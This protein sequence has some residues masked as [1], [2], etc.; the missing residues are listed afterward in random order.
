[1]KFVV[2][3]IVRIRLWILMRDFD[4]RIVL[5]TGSEEEEVEGEEEREIGGE[6][7]W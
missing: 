4:L 3:V 5:Q 7:A 1:M 6:S 2:L